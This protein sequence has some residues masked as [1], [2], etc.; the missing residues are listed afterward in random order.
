MDREGYVELR[1]GVID[2]GLCTLCGGCVASC[3]V[4][5]LD[6]AKDSITLKGECI[7][8]GTCLRIC[9]GKG[10]DLSSHEEELF[11]RRRKK[12]IGTRFGIHIERKQLTSSVM[13]FV[14]ASYYGGRVASVLISAMEKGLIDSALM[15]DWGD[16][17]L[18]SQGKAVMARSRDDILSMVSSKYV[19]SPVLTLLRE[20]QEDD[21]VK[22]LAVV[23][24]PCHVQ[25]LRNMMKDTT[26]SK[27][28]GKVRYV[29]GLNCGA[30]LRSEDDWRASISPLLGADPG[31]IM[32]FRAHKV[33]GTTI[34]VEARMKDGGQISKVVPIGRY[35]SIFAKGPIWGRCLLCT[36]Y[37]AELSDIT[38]GAPVIRSERGKELVDRALESG[39]LKRSSYKKRFTQNITD[40]YAGGR[41][42]RRASKYI[43]KRASVREPVPEYR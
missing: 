36:D 23:G 43:R 18:I 29:V 2:A 13:E 27:F 3:P 28:T 25:A 15:T 32:E 35:L 40:L 5:V 34:K 8:C 42:K 21:S 10:I 4:S 20:A 9:P 33:T 12:V 17:G 41:K 16:E 39:Y 14:K 37:S 30:P 19:F 31:S 11:G 22:H 1:R 26:A 38:F 6:F 24:L 7:E